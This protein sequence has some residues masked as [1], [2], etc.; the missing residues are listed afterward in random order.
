M[1]VPEL[2]LRAQA[3]EDVPRER[4]GETERRGRDDERVESRRGRLIN[5]RCPVK[6]KDDSLLSLPLHL[7]PLF[8]EQASVV[9]F[10]V[11][12]LFFKWLVLRFFFHIVR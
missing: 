4:R 11:L 1:Q 5:S 8:D 12:I 9:K 6:S 10:G 7:K 3:P 2:L